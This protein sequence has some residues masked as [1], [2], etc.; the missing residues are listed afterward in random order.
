MPTTVVELP[1]LTGGYA[2]KPAVAKISNRR[3]VGRLFSPI[4]WRKH[5]T[6]LAPR[7]GGRFEEIPHL[8]F[9]R[10]KPENSGLCLFD[11]EGNEWTEADLIAD[12]TIHWTAEWLN[13]YELWHLTGEW[14]APRVGYESIAQMDAAEART[15]RE[16]AAGV[17]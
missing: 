14:L 8:I 1:H 13:Y 9:D 16:L 12:T 3:Q 10:K 11:P 17:Y 15:I 7:P 2:D 5:H 4:G 6:P